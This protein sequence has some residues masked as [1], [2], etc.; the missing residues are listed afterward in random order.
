MTTQLSLSSMKKE[1][2]EEERKSVLNSSTT[3]VK[4]RDKSKTK[5]ILHEDAKQ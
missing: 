3:E 2:E 4:Q 1:R 5:I